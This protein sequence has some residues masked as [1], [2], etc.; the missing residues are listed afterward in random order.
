M[1]LKAFTRW[2]GKPLTGYGAVVK[3]GNL[4]NTVGA[5]IPPPL[6]VDI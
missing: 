1:Y 2:T 5:K 3:E 4:L 6:L